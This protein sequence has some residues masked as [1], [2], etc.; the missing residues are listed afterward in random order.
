MADH[1]RQQST[2]TNDPL[3]IIPEDEVQEMLQKGS[4][5]I[6]TLL[7]QEGKLA[8]IVQGMQ[9]KISI[10]KSFTEFLL[11]IIKLF[12]KAIENKTITMKNSARESIKSEL[13]DIAQG[14]HYV[15][16]NLKNYN[17]HD[18]PTTSY[19]ASVAFIVRSAIK[20]QDIIKG[21]QRKQWLR[22]FRSA[23]NISALVPVFER[24]TQ[25][26][27]DIQCIECREFFELLGDVEELKASLDDIRKR[28]FSLETVGIVTAV[29][30]AVGG[31]ICLIVGGILLVTPAAPA[32]VPLLIAGGAGV[33]AALATGSGTE[34]CAFLARKRLDRAEAK[35]DRKGDKLVCNKTTELS[36]LCSPNT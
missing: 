17:P 8:S 24:I 36:Q 3:R 30:F 6:D 26:V 2:Q 15:L 19:D 10:S 14:L 4:R 1:S 7:R 5:L 16:M 28:V 18:V 34:L 29:L 12:Q 25:V 21:L 31:V 22:W 20:V 32:G 35:G 9:L 23:K 33:G 11:Y 27:K 13:T